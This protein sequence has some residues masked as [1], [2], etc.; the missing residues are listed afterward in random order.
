MYQFI[1]NIKSDKAFFFYRGSVA[2][3][4]LLKAMDIR[5][6]DEVILQS[7]TCDIVPATVVRAGGVPVYVDIDPSTFNIAPDKI[8]ARI[9]VKTKAIIVQHTYGIPAEMKPILDTARKHNLWVIEDSCH[10][11]GSK[12][13]GQEVGTFGDVAFYSFGWH[14]PLVLGKGGVAV[15]NNPTLK[16]KVKE[17]Y[18]GF[19]TP[20]YKELIIL[21]IQYFS[22]T[23]LL[24]PSFF[25]CMRG[26]Y[27]EL[28][29]WGGLWG[30][31]T[32]IPSRKKT[33]AAQDG[34]VEGSVGPYNRKMI[35]FQERRLSRKL[36][37]F[38]RI[39]AH[40]RWVVSQY[41]RLFSQVGYNP[42][43]LDSRF[44]PIYFKYPLL[45]DH[46]KDI[47]DKAP[48]A[49]IELS[50]LFSSPVDPLKPGF[51]AHWKALGYQKGMCPVSEY[52]ADRIV[53]LPVHSGI[54][55]KDIERTIGF[56]S[57]FQ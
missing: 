7:F 55:A 18:E 40:K 1:E 53:A 38:D 57:S 4:A 43:E 16:Q 15:V 42:L 46:K 6:G 31:I 19:V 9:T 5:P 24:K 34:K 45:S 26:V 36:D 48:R 37:H 27:R 25:W 8:E 29:S 22:Y 3:Y 39:V 52:I 10:A 23:L 47:F 17:L 21:Y 11:L 28:A 41:E 49:R 12:Y 33:G 30:L 13:S 2:L 35:P 50:Y 14:K 51:V 56:L 32:G 54:R 20:L 44:E